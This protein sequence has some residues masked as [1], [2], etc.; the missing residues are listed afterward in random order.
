M[1]HLISADLPS[2][3]LAL[4]GQLQRRLA[5]QGRQPQLIDLSGEGLLASLDGPAQQLTCFQ[6]GPYQVLA[7]GRIKPGLMEWLELLQLQEARPELM[8]P[9]PGLTQLLQCCALADWLAPAENTPD[10]ALSDQALLDGV[11]PDLLPPEVASDQFDSIVLLP[12]LP[13]ALELMELARTGPALLD[14]WLE[15]LLL[16]WQQ[17]RKSLSRLD[18]VLRLSLPDGNALRLNPP[19]RQR[20]DHLAA[21]LA[22][23]GRHQWLCVLDGGGGQTSLLG[24]RLCRIYLREFQ[25]ARLWVTGPAAGQAQHALA[26]VNGPTLVGH[27]GTLHHGGNPLEAWLG[28]PWAAERSVEWQQQGDRPL[29]R[30]LLPGLRKELLKVQQIDQELIIQ[31]GGSSRRLPL[32]EFLGEKNCS[33]AKILGRYLQLQFD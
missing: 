32:P 2:D 28:A 21:H 23:P 10:A 27:G 12:P 31:V 30:L 5:G 20:L 22:D 29:C 17:T 6:C 13:Q 25:L 8:P 19:W 26:D 4:V 14:Q 16:W 24:D 7:W 3:G 9:L 1:L 18:L 33:G 11:A 15:P